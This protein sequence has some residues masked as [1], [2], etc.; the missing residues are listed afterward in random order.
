MLQL[1]S[2]EV[3]LA[4]KTVRFDCDD[5]EAQRTAAEKR[6]ALINGQLNARSGLTNQ[7]RRMLNREANMLQ[8]WL[9]PDNDPKAKKRRELNRLRNQRRRILSGERR[10]PTKRE[11]REARR[12]DREPHTQWKRPDYSPPVVLDKGGRAR[13]RRIR[14]A[15][16]KKQDWFKRKHALAA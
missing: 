11:C 9:S 4:T 3:D 13:L 5:H 12:F 2:C 1:P 16:F 6:L 7:K 14:K 8:R 10:K 15:I